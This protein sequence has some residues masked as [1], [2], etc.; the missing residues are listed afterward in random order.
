MYRTVAQL[1][2]QTRLLATWFPAYFTRVQLPEPSVEG[3]PVFALRLRAGTGP[4]RRGALLVGGTHA[5]EL[6]NPQAIVE[7]AVDLFVSYATGSDLVY[8]GQRWPAAD[9]KLILESLDI[10]MIPCVNPDGREHVMTV[11]KMWRKSRA[12]NAGTT[13]VGVDL[14]RN[15]DFLWGVTA[16]Q[17]SCSPCAETYV[18]PS[19]VS[20]PETR[21]VRHLLDTRRID[22][23]ADVHSYS[24]L[25]LWPWGHAPAQTTNP[26]MR[27]TTLPTGTCS[28]I[29]TG[30]QEHIS[31]RDLLRFQTVGGR[32][33]DAIAAVRGRAYTSKA[34]VALYPTTGTFGD[35]VYSRHISDSALRKT[36]GFTFE[37]G[38]WM[39]SPEKSFQPEDPQ[40]VIRDAKSGMVA[41]LQQSIC[42]I[43]LIG[44]EFFRAQTE[45]TALRKVRDKLLATTDAGREW[46][47]LFE[48]IEVPVITLLLGDRDLFTETADLV[49][50][51]AA[52]ARDDTVKLT[53][54]EVDA[55]L[56]VI[57]KLRT[58]LTDPALR[59]DVRAIEVQLDAMRG[60]T[61]AKAV[62]RLMGLPPGAKAAAGTRAKQPAAGKR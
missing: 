6:M 59:S 58:H 10:W 26:A 51:S 7:L 9:V 8:G 17:T 57:R 18:G 4:E 37:T 61:M 1:D 43:E 16:G 32:I 21:N 50:R 54:D 46:I 41:L 39:G 20:E 23:F 5:R 2:S 60:I 62:E 30:Y 3:R 34:G 52:L 22:T 11:Y 27:F 55:G 31:P 45:I 44:A 24:E 38:P 14:N 13:C 28:D 19:A 47:A 56:K 25:I 48:R 53:D 12:I 42:A 15:S 33:V 36:Y 49:K 29:R 40:P 35:Y